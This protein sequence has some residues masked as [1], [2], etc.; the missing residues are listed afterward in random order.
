MAAEETELRLLEEGRR[1]Y[2]DKY[3]GEGKLRAPMA[4]ED[5]LTQY[6]L[7]KIVGNAETR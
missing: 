4:E 3:D 5:F 2:R 7:E 6:L 1:V